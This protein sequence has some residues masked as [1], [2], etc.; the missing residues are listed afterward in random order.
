MTNAP[1][2]LSV[3]MKQR[4]FCH[5][6]YERGIYMITL[7]VEGRRPIL[8]RLE[9]CAVTK[10]PLGESVEACWREIPRRHPEIQLLACIVMP[11]HFHG[12]LFVRTRM[13]RH[14]GE[15]V[16]GFK[17][18][19]TKAYRLGGR[20]SGES[21]SREPPFGDSPFGDSPYMANPPNLFAPGYHDRILT[22][23]GQLKTLFRYIADN[24]RRLALI[25][26]H[27]NYFT[28]INQLSLAGRVYAAYG[29]PFLLNRPDRLQI[30]CSRRISPEALAAEQARLLDAA[31]RG[32]VLVSPCISPGEKLIARA[33]MEEGLPL[34]ALKA[35]GF[36]PRYKPP[37]RSFDACAKGKLLLLAPVE[38][39]AMYGAPP[40]RPTHHNVAKQPAAARFGAAPY[41][42]RLTRSQCLALNQLAADICGPGA[43]ALNYAGLVPLEQ[44]HSAAPIPFFS[45]P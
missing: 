45:G 7:E 44:P 36:A 35:D 11:D 4:C 17:I 31:A 16:R 28:R 29:N 40:N 24:P 20:L 42:A 6:Y 15:I 21:P 2:I 9:G 27:P 30:Q 38:N 39:R 1:D 23:R 32:A 41:M 37:G 18:G 43:A 10:T 25:R 26:Q 22:H 3:K 19:C 33:A 5:D 13:R 12:L 8:G 34:I 14:L